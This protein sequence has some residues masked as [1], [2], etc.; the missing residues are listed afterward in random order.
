MILDSSAADRATGTPDYARLVDERFGV[1]LGL[2]PKQL[3][4]DEPASL[5][6]FHGRVNN[7]RKLGQWYGDRI[8][9]GTSFH[10]PEAA[11]RAAIGE[12]V[13]RYCGN[14]V[15][16][17]LR[18]ASWE[19]LSAAGERAVDPER[20][21][22]YS[23]RQHATPGFPFVRFTRDLPVFWVAGRHLGSGDDAWVPASMVYPNYLVDSLAEEPRTHFVNLSGIATGVGREDA[24]RSALEELIERDA[25]TVWWTSGAP[26][27]PLDLHSAPAVAAAMAPRTLDSQPLEYRLFAIENVFGV[28]VV[29]GLMRDPKNDLV[30][31]GVA[32]RPDPVAASLKSLAEAVHLRGYSREMLEPEGRIWKM[33]EEGLLDQRVY[34]GYRR[35]RGYTENFRDDWHDVVDLGCHAQLYLD[36]RM[37]VHLERFERDVPL[38]PIASVPGLGDREKLD[39]RSAYLRRLGAE[40][41][42]AYSVD[43]TTSDVASVGLAVVRVVVP[44]LYGNA[45]AAFPALG[46]RRLYEDPVRLGWFGEPVAEEDLVLAPMPHT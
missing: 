22:L 44:G 32:C 40:G 21:A 28:P 19:E 38:R 9:L 12:A 17:T 3:E 27:R 43:V 14:F 2:H 46:G 13:E 6:S 16:R 26:P 36:P 24:E 23:E 33:M 41:L 45:P 25:I 29:G 31:L 18:K 5:V 42:E 1:V 20:L 39:L 7:S 8:S 35:D 11:R 4:D 30:A 15:P 37:R 10:D 34:K